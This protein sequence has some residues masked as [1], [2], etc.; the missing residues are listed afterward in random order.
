MKITPLRFVS[1]SIALTVSFHALADAVVSP[2]DQH[3]AEQLVG[4]VFSSY[5]SHDD[6][7]F[8]TSSAKTERG[9]LATVPPMKFE[10][11]SM[12]K[13]Q[14]AVWWGISMIPVRSEAEARAYEDKCLEAAKGTAYPYD[15]VSRLTYF[16]V[17]DTAEFKA[18]AGRIPDPIK[19]SEAVHEAFQAQ[20]RTL[21][22]KYKTTAQFF[23]FSSRDERR[24]DINRDDFLSRVLTKHV[25]IITSDYRGPRFGI[26]G[27]AMPPEQGVA[28]YERI[29]RRKVGTNRRG[30]TLEGTVGLI[31]D[32]SI[33][34]ALR[35]AINFIRDGGKIEMSNNVDEAIAMAT[36][37]LRASEAQEVDPKTLKVITR[38]LERRSRYLTDPSELAMVKLRFERKQAYAI[39]ART[40]Q[41]RIVAGGITFR[42]GNLLSSDTVF[43]RVRK[44][45][46]T[47]E[48]PPT[49][50]DDPDAWYYD[51][52]HP[53]VNYSNLARALR[54]VESAMAKMRAGLP[55]RSVVMVSEFTRKGGGDNIG[56]LEYLDYLRAL[57]TLPYVDL[58]LDEPFSLEKDLPFTPAEMKDWLG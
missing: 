17:P 49:S 18:M 3:C 37:Q 23:H 43:Y 10:A 22:D 16:I 29:F 27:W 50:P 21:W 33:R 53:D 19:D 11:V 39:T 35:T 54:V 46:Y 34:K 20:A 41:G 26:T 36:Y 52:D 42:D 30:E 28:I 40:K 38:S 8:N 1:I 14:G 9:F 6:F 44:E 51:P 56:L 4:N 15:G 7:T 25:D 55:L 31:E 48:Q 57:R 47:P 45:D 58:H 5:K 24:I 13:Q 32:A 12:A 2:E